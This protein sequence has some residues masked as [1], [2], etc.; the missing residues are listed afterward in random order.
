MEHT[1]KQRLLPQSITLRVS[2][3]IYVI[4][5]EPRQVEFPEQLGEDH[6]HF[7]VRE[8]AQAHRRLAY[9]FYYLSPLPALSS[10]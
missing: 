1:P 2:L 4:A 8:T 6:A 3:L 5:V 10:H 7:Q 9:Y